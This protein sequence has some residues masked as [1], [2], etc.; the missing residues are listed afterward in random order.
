MQTRG[1]MSLL[2]GECMNADMSRKESQFMDWYLPAKKQRTVPMCMR[3]GEPAGAVN[4]E[5]TV[6]AFLGPAAEMLKDPE[7]DGNYYD[8]YDSEGN[9]VRAERFIAT[10]PDTQKCVYNRKVLISLL[11]AMTSDWVMF[12]VSTDYPGRITGQIG[13]LPCAALI[14]PRVE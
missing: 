6:I 7:M 14:A 3:E 4:P 1:R 10:R 5:H 9:F 13:D 8:L 2:R 12:Q 11:E